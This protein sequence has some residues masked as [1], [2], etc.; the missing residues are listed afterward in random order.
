MTVPGGFASALRRHRT[1]L[2]PALLL[3]GSLAAWAAATEPWSGAPEPPQVETP[4]YEY[5]G[6][7]T[8]VRIRFRPLD[9]GFGEY[10]WGLDLK[11]NHDYPQAEK[12]FSRIVEEIT[13]IDVQQGTGIV[14]E[15]DDP[16]LFDYPWAYM[17]EP[18]F[19]SPTDEQVEILRQYLLRGGFLVIDDFFDQPGR[20]A[21]WSNFRHQIE[22]VFPGV[23]LYPMQ[24]DHPIFRTFFELDD[25]DF[26]VPEMGDWFP[27]AIYGVFEDNDP[28]K[29]LLAIVNYNMDVGDYWEWSDT[30]FYPAHMTQKGFKLGINYL[31]YGLLY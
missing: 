26:S 17:C 30:A 27:P 19:W 6:R 4:S 8:F 2:L 1:L 5:D 9:W 11:W 15:I 21:Q 10:S 16:R 29:R 22:R 7:F 28:Q 3:C 31:A 23:I 12:N 25:L 13:G 18:G 14:L 24:V 20:S